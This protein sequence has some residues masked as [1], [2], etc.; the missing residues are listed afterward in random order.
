MKI[1]TALFYWGDTP[2]VLMRHDIREYDYMCTGVM[3]AAQVLQG[4]QAIVV[5]ADDAAATVNELR[6]R[7]VP[8]RVVTLGEAVTA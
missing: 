4:G 8:V 7:G 2:G 1:D 5:A 3:L 6:A